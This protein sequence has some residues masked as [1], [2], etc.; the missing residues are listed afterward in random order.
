M[1]QPVIAPKQA[2]PY[3]RKLL[4]GCSQNPFLTTGNGAS[5]N[6]TYGHVICAAGSFNGVKLV[7]NN[8]SGSVATVDNTIIGVGSTIYPGGV[9]NINNP[10]GGWG[11]ALGSI[12]IPAG[13]TK[14][15][16]QYITPLIPIKSVA[17][18]SG[19]ADGGLYP[20]LFVRNFIATANTNSSYATLPSPWTTLYGSSNNL[21]FS[22]QF[23]VNYGVNSVATPS[24]WTSGGGTNAPV[25]MF[26]GAIFQYD[27]LFTS[28]CGIGDSIMAGNDDGATTI[29]AY[30]FIACASIL[31][32]GKNVSWFSG[33]CSGA[34]IQQIAYNANTLVT[35]VNADIYL[36]P[37]YTINSDITTQSAWDIQWEYAMQIVEIIEGLGKRVI[38]MSPF[39]NSG[40]TPTQNG[41]RLNQL[42]RWQAYVNSGGNGCSVEVL[43]Q[44][45]GQANPGQWANPAYTNGGTHPSVAGNLY[46]GQQLLQPVLQQMVQ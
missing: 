25:L 12:A 1:F 28:V 22:M 41:Y 43:A 8:T 33:G 26:G 16:S 6:D 45:V 37:C 31:A 11:T 34:T 17:R 10:D 7:F 2:V 29:M 9:N 35:N 18:A 40:F 13:S 3:Q 39:P 36:V 23:N 20:L 15:P 14:E 38:L 46:I 5:Q 30:G 24:N 4:S 19:D 42:A 44:Q 27:Q 32:A 21:G